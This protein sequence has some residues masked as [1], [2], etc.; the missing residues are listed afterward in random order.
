MKPFLK[1]SFI[2]AGCMVCIGLMFGIVGVVFGG[3]TKLVNMLEN[4]ELS[5]GPDE[6]MYDV[7]GNHY[8]FYYDHPDVEWDEADDEGITYDVSEISNMELKIGGGVL[9]LIPYDGDKYKIVA[10]NNNKYETGVQNGTLVVRSKDDSTNRRD[11]RIY[12]PKDYQ[13]ENVKIR[14]GAGM[15]DIDE[16]TCD[17]LDIDVGAGKLDANELTANE[18]KIELGAGSADMDGVV[19]GNSE[20]EIGLGTLDLDGIIEGDI[21]VKCDMGKVEMDLE[22]EEEDYNYDVDCSAGTVSVGDYNF[23][24]LDSGRTMDNGGSYDIDINCSMGAVAIDF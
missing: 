14:L 16:L 10:S 6:F 13:L 20:F 3:H 19:F 9:K 2:I 24:G 12:L 17:T 11:I 5:W 22:G 7:S 4:G 1:Y 23:S 8:A 15:A 18:T 21:S